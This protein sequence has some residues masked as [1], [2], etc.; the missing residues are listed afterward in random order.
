MRTLLLDADIFA[1]IAAAVSEESFDFGT[2][3]AVAVYEDEARQAVDLQISELCDTLKA[4]TVMVCLTDS[5]NWRKEFDPTYKSNR[6]N[7]KKPLLLDM[8][9]DYLAHEYRSYIRPRL[10]ADDIMG[11]LAT[12]EKIIKGEKIIVS[13]D[14]DLRTIPGLVYNPNYPHLGVL[15]ISE[16]DADRFHMWQTICGDSTDGYPGCRGVGPGGEYVDGAFVQGP[17]SLD[18]AHDLITADRGELWDIVVE[19][20]ASKGQTEDDAIHQAR[21]AHI[22]RAPDYNFKTKGVRLWNPLFLVR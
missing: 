6:A 9:K 19:A 1:Y 20:Y 16:L 5:V 14:K 4:D 3:T 11:I 7:A 12:H 13:A 8:V 22:L 18:Y 17:R 15:E 2:G 10:E 21:L